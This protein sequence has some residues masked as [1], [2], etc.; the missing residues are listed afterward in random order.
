MHRIII[1]WIAETRI[2]DLAAEERYFLENDWNTRCSRTII[3]FHTLQ[4]RYRPSLGIYI[5]I[6]DPLRWKER[7]KE[8]KE[9]QERNVDEKKEEHAD[10]I[11]RAE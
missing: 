4:Q 1:Q 10:T 2:C 3:L 7:E 8:K 11:C 9:L 5:L 6:H